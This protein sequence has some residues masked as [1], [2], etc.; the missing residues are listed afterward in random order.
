MTVI[1]TASIQGLLDKQAIEEILMRYSRAI[2]RNDPD[3]LRLVYW[4][5]A[6]DDHLLYEGDVDGLVSF[7][8]EFTALMPT[9]HFL[10]NR[11]IELLDDAAA[12]SETYYQAYHNMPAEGG[13][14]DVTLLGRYLDDFVKRDG[15]W[16]IQ[17]R[18]VVV[19]GYTQVAATSDW[20]NGLLAGVR[21]RGRGR[22]E[23]PLYTTRLQSVEA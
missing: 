14:Q 9:H 10:G 7:C 2:D 20:D 8:M 6:Y 3:L 11:L 17:R 15:E 12:F 18:I 22:P 23:D 16:R 19:D 21:M 5:D 1:D 4:P 13:R